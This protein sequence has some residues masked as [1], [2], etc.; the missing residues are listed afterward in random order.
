V[1]TPV[2]GTCDGC[3][4]TGVMIDCPSGIWKCTTCEPPTTPVGRQSASVPLGVMSE[5]RVQRAAMSMLFWGRRRD[6]E[7]IRG[8]VA[9]LTQDERDQVVAVLESKRLDVLTDAELSGRML[10]LAGS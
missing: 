8:V 3:G 1:S 4:E 6:D 9:G 10:L 5:P 7:A 2:L